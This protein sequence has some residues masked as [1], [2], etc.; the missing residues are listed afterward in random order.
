[1]YEE[2]IRYFNALNVHV[3]LQGQAGTG[4]TAVVAPPVPLPERDPPLPKQVR[5]KFL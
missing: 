5:V 4:A 2:R 3:K 1:M